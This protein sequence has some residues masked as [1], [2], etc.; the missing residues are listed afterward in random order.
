MPQTDAPLRRTAALTPM[1]VATAAALV[2]AIALTIGGANTIILVI[3]WIATA[4]VAG[5]TIAVARR[6]R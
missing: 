5:A 3:V 6:D 1:L 4:V 2:V